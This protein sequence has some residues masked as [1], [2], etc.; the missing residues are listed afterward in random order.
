MGAT[1]CGGP[2]VDDE[3]GLDV[4]TALPGLRTGAGE[5]EE[6]AMLLDGATSVIFVPGYGLAV[7]QAQHVVREL[8][9]LLHALVEPGR[10]TTFKV[11]LPRA[12][13]RAQV[14]RRPAAVAAAGSGPKP[15]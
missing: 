11:F 15:R 6:V 1:A 5:A 4:G 2:K 9:D 10:G 13:D 3:R 7:A 8:G 14:P 12:D